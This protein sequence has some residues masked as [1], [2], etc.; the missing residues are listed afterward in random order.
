LPP[1]A[2]KG[3]RILRP[4]L[5]FW[6]VSRS[7]VAIHSIL[8]SIS[9]GTGADR[10]RTAVIHAIRQAYRNLDWTALKRLVEAP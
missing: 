1:D 6:R 8:V 2:P 3:S 10:A 5:E 4:K 9:G 7:P